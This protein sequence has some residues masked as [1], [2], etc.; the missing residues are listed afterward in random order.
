M[1]ISLIKCSFYKYLN[2]YFSKNNFISQIFAFCSWDILIVKVNLSLRKKSPRGSKGT[3]SRHSPIFLLMESHQCLLGRRKLEAR[4]V[5]GAK[6][7][8]ELSSCP[9]TK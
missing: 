7:E 3:D 6:V 1:Q 2:K 9:K 8:S 4:N 5:K